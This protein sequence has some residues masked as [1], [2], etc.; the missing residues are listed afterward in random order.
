MIRAIGRYPQVIVTIFIFGVLGLFIFGSRYYIEQSR[1]ALALETAEAFEISISTLHLFYSKE[2]VPRAE[3]AG[4]ELTENFRETTDKIPFPATMTMNYGEELHANRTGM[5]TAMYSHYPFPNRANRELDNFQKQ[6]L[7]FLEK[8]PEDP[9]VKLNTTDDGD[10]IRYARSIIMEPDCVQ[11]HN[12]AGVGKPWKVGDFRGVREVS[13]DLPRSSVIENEMKNLTIGLSITIA[14][15]GMLLM[16]PT[17][18]ILQSTSRA[19]EKLAAELA[20]KNTDLQQADLQKSRLM[21]GV[22]HDLKTPLNAIIGFSDAMQNELF[23]KMNNEKY[24]DYA[25]SIHSSGVHLMQMIE[26]LLTTG[27]IQDGGWSYHEEEIDLRKLLHSMD[28]ILRVTVEQADMELTLHPAKQD[29]FL[30]GDGRAIRQILTNLVDNAVKYSKASQID[31]RCDVKKN[32]LILSVQDNGIGIP[33]RD[34]KKLKEEH[35]RGKTSQENNSAGLGIGLWLVDNF[36]KIHGSELIINS[37]ETQGS[38]FEV[39]FPPERISLK[40]TV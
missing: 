32:E 10:V 30:R 6:A 20:E 8:N 27:I 22:G 17:V 23:G 26:Q 24:K 12:D 5:S 29:V 25:S 35:Y 37:T 39:H 40:T 34:L 1:Q 3:A 33:E 38:H 28:P 14:V 18:N 13:I 36:A 15:L 11:C 9:F 7:A 16:L 21:K 4:V 19:N 2:I 31:I